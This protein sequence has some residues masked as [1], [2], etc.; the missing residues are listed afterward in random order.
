VQRTGEGH[1]WKESVAEHIAKAA[2]ESSFGE[3]LE[4][5]GGAARP[6]IFKFHH[7]KNNNRLKLYQPNASELVSHFVSTDRYAA[8]HS[9]P[10]HGYVPKQD[11]LRHGS[12]III[13][14]LH[15]II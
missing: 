15:K 14:I 12:V 10:P 9:S 6:A 2:R 4:V 5:R 7:K 1:R 8:P 11:M 3:S 13:W